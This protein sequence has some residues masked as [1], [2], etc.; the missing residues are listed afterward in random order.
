MS[1]FNVLEAAFKL[2]MIARDM[3]AQRETDSE[4]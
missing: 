3:S 2:A 1:F 4:K